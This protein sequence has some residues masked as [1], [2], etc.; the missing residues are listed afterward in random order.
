MLRD[1]F[2]SEEKCYLTETEEQLE[3]F[4]ER[5]YHYW[6]NR[7]KNEKNDMEASHIRDV[8]AKTKFATLELL[9]E[10]RIKNEYVK[11]PIKACLESFQNICICRSLATT[12]DVSEFVRIFL[13]I[14]KDNKETIDLKLCILHLQDF[15]TIYSIATNGVIM[16][17]RHKDNDTLL[18]CGT[19]EMVGEL[20][21]WYILYEVTYSLEKNTS[22]RPR[23]F[24]DVNNSR[25]KRKNC[26][27]CDHKQMK[28]S[29]INFTSKDDYENMVINVTNRLSIL[30]MP[31]Q[32]DTSSV[33]HIIIG[34]TTTLVTELDSMNKS[35]TTGTTHEQHLLQSQMRKH[36]QI[37][38]DKVAHILKSILINSCIMDTS[39]FPNS[40]DKVNF[41]AR[42]I[43]MIVK[44]WANKKVQ[45][46][47]TP[48]SKIFNTKYRKD[49]S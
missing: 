34:S 16:K 45:V 21:G 42:K 4:V 26:N 46:T 5:D 10:V 24:I 6:I 43:L 29:K 31:L 14:W 13:K 28:D 47:I 33:A 37:Y 44:E 32:F 40:S 17:L 22:K 18:A 19:G 3:I 23:K 25:E 15:L 8:L 1:F 41:N 36:E 48:L 2:S 49:I 30:F 38:W 27:A 11:N 9:T 7:A 12:V 20:I 35:M 39:M